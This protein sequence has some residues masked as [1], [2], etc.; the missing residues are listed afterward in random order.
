LETKPPNSLKVSLS[1]EFLPGGPNLPEK[2]LHI[3]RSSSILNP[4]YPIIV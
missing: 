1:G 3:L 2:S 4:L